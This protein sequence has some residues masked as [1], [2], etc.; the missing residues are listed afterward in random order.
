MS[1]IDKL[2][3]QHPELNV[4]IIDL[5]SKIDP[6]GTNKYVEF[7]IKQIKNSYDYDGDN[8]NLSLHI[9]TEIVGYLNVETLNEFDRHCKAGRIIKNDISQYKKWT[10]MKESVRI[11]NEVVKQKELEKQVIKLLDNNDY[12]VVIP[13]S[14]EASKIYGANTKWC[15]TQEQHWKNYI[16]V[17]KLI[18]IMDKV[19]NDKYAVSIKT[20]SKNKIQ[21][22]LSDDTEVSP[23]TL[24][25]SSEVIT[26]IMNEIN[27]DESI[28]EMEEYS[29]MNNKLP[30]PKKSITFDGWSSVQQLMDEY[31]LHIDTSD[32]NGFRYIGGV[33]LSDSNDNP[34]LRYTIRERNR[35]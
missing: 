13:L 21:G 31:G 22:W 26:L 32:S 30:Y 15:T 27:K 28:V 29:K 14:Y 4:S 35:G 24:P 6:S 18:Y 8:T 2:K 33:D 16:D 12:C 9:I 3:E 25:I 34:H 7:L 17:Y 10:E 23:L 19:K 20:K 1:K 11:A 5:L